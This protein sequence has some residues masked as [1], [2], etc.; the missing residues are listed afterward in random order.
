MIHRELVITLLLHKGDNKSICF[1]TS[2]YDQAYRSNKATWLQAF[3]LF[4]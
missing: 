1:A 2:C 3:K 4:H